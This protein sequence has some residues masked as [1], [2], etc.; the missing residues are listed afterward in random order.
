MA[1]NTPKGTFPTLYQAA[2]AHGISWDAMKNRCLSINYPDY[3]SNDHDKESRV[4]LSGFF[5]GH[6]YYPKP[7]QVTGKHWKVAD[8]SNMGHARRIAIMTPRGEF[9]SM[10]AAAE[11]F[12]VS[13]QSIHNWI[14]KPKYAYLG[15]KT[16]ERIEIDV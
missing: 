11:A 8:T 14:H 2:K 3:I 1:I 9:E 4:G 16:I 7:G 12:N 13:R 10:T 5:P 6:D 15:F